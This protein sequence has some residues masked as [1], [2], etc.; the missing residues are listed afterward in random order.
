MA[1]DTLLILNAGSSSIKLTLFDRALNRRLTGM[2]DGIGGTSR[3]RLGDETQ[4]RALPDHTAALQAVLEGLAARGVALD[5]LCA[6][7][8]RVVH[9]GTGLTGPRRITPETRD[10]IAACIP[11]APLHNP[12]N[13]AAIDSIAR[14]APR[15]P[16]FASFDTSFHRTMPEVAARYALPAEYAARGIRRYGFHGLSYSALVR[17]LPGLTGA[18]LPARVLACHLGNGASLCAIREGR[19][20]DTTMGY[21]PL[22]GLTMGTRVGRIDANAVLRLVEEDGLEATRRLL[23]HGAGLLGLSGHSSDMRALQEDGGPDSAF[24]VAH[25]CYAAARQ[26]AGLLA[27]MGG[28]DAVVFT[29]GIGENAPQVRAAILQHLNWLGVEIDAESNSRNAP[30]LHAD[31]SRVEAWVV[32]ADEEREIARDA[33]AL[34][35]GG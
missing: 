19:S 8:H 33:M 18:P 2:A 25:F 10:A 28:C 32:P 30:R 35:D 1:A 13:L 4:P 3:L 24:A 6:V 22:E 15:L 34:L 29:G 14:L 9:G 7:G 17:N 21:S 12:H 5:A 16:Q 31:T 20:V 27:A 26:G 11:L 23:N